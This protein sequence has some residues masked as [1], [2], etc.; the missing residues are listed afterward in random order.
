MRNVLREKVEP[1]LLRVCI[2]IATFRRPQLLRAL[3]DALAALTFHK[4]REPSLEV[5]VVDNDAEQSARNVCQRDAFP[6]R[7]RYICEPE[8]GIVRARNR[9]I[10][11][12]SEADFLAFIDD[13]ETPDSR[14]I[15]ELLWTQ[16]RFQSE[17]VSGALLPVFEQGVP[18]WIRS[19]KFFERPV[20]VTGTRVQLCSAGN[21]LIQSGVFAAVSGFDERFNFSGCE[22]THFFIR[23]RQAGFQMVFSREAVAYEP[24][25]AQRANLAWLLRRG[26][27][28]GNGWA[29]CERSLHPGWRVALLRVLKELAH[30]GKGL[31]HLPLASFLGKAHLARSLQTIS[32]ATGTLAGVAGYRFL[33][34]RKVLDASPRQPHAKQVQGKIETEA[35]P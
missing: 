18:K 4:M 15:D 6:W 17:V 19:G 31:L 23:V 12:A 16:F 34:Y 27:Q 10:A 33:P 13:D 14:W 20:P 30:M 24:I 22:D 7:L 1:G 28:A 29:H 5:I 11:A 2:C 8:R 3:L 26:F 25:S 9:L 35:L 21:V 32:T